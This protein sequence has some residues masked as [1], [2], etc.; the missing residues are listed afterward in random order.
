[1]EGRLGTTGLPAGPGR[2]SITGQGGDDTM[3]GG[4]GPYYFFEDLLTDRAGGGS[5][6]LR[7]GPGVDQADYGFRVPADGALRVSLDG[8][9]NDGQG[10]EGDNVGTDVERVAGAG[11]ARNV[12]VGPGGENELTGGSQRDRI[13]GVGQ[14]QAARQWRAR[15][16]EGERRTRHVHRERLH[17]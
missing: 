3:D 16:P 6:T 7:G 9:A 12:L 11:S 10:G 1:M 4:E 8:G 17:A 13:T 14:R 2:D 15:C 5:D